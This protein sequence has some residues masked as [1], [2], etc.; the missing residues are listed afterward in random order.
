MSKL[1]QQPFQAHF[2]SLFRIFEEQYPGMPVV[3][4]ALNGGQYHM[5][6]PLLLFD[7]YKCT[8]HEPFTMVLLQPAYEWIDKL[9]FVLRW[10]MVGIAQTV[11]KIVTNKCDNSCPKEISQNKSTPILPLR[12]TSN[13]LPTENNTK[14][15]RS[16]VECWPKIDQCREVV[17]FW[18]SLHHSTLPPTPAKWPSNRGSYDARCR[19]RN[20]PL[21][22]ANP[23]HLQSLWT[24]S[25]N[26]IPHKFTL[27]MA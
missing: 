19:L 21:W 25:R 23:W 17:M 7:E 24:Q 3:K 11:P 16:S 12:P 8:G 10:T 4:M 15:N 18:S 27:L 1:W 2:K 20:G 9:L 5:L 22:S 6:E 14:H 13:Q 26:H